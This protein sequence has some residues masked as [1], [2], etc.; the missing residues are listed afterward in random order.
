MTPDGRFKNG[1]VWHGFKYKDRAGWW[2]RATDKNGNE[3]DT[4]EV[5]DTPPLFT[6]TQYVGSWTQEDVEKSSNL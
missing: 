6:L 5:P 1:D 4:Q 2:F 3:Y